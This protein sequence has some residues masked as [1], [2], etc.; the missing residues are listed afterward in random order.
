MSFSANVS[1][2]V[3]KRDGRTEEVSFDKVLE[4][5]RRAAQGLQVNPTAIAQKVLGQIYDGVKTT[6]L[7]DLTSQLA[8]SLA[9]VHPD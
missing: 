8:A 4:R 3:V 9:T 7:D 2:Q 5:V 1:M 6:E